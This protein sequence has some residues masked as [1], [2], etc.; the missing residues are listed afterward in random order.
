MLEVNRE[1]NWNPPE[2]GAG[3]FGEWLANNVD[4][5]LSRDRYWGTPLPVWV[6]DQKPDHVEVIGSYA[7]LAERWGKPLPERFDPHKPFIDSYTWTCKCGGTMRRA[8]EVIDTWFD[9][10]SMP[11]AQW[12]YPFEHEAEFKAHFPA[13]YICEGVDQTR[14]WFYSL[15]AIA[16]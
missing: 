8:T 14:G 1:V 12:H 2:I 15:L 13:D 4:W 3:R 10:G 6:C 9:S 16:V 7:D 11:Y 5:A